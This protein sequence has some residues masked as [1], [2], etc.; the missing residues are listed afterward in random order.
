MFS[1]DSLAVIRG[2]I[3]IIIRVERKEFENKNKM[4]VYGVYTISRTWPK[5]NFVQ[6]T[7]Y[8]RNI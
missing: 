5:H 3:I 2:V 8:E 4:L 7:H 6:L 1:N